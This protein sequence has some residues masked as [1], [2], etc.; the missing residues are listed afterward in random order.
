MNPKP[1]MPEVMCMET[2]IPEFR[3]RHKPCQGGGFMNKVSLI[4]GKDRRR[5]I[6]KSLEQIS[7]DI[8]KNLKPGRIIIKPNF[9]SSSIQ[10]AAS[11]VDQIRG[12]LDYLREFYKEKIIIAEAACDDTTEA[13]KDFGYHNLLKEYN[14]ELIDLNKGPFEKVH[15]LDEKNRTIHVMVSS[16]LLDRNNYLISAAKLKTHDSV[17][18]TLSIKNTAMGCIF[19]KDKIRVHQGVKHLN[20]NIAELSKSVWPDLAI[21]DGFVGMEGNGPVDGSPIHAGV[22]VSGADPL[23]ADRVACELM[24]IDFNKVGYLRYC[25]E[26][27]LG[28]ADL[29]QIEIV[30][31]AF[32]E[33]VMPFRLHS[34]VKEQYKWKD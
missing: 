18:V 3:Q 4:K 24:G 1:F 31:H 23:A 5:N 34:S 27:G 32:R 28:E 26:K 2:P 9:V 12:I 25:S 13:Y 16:L 30:G 19:T 10:L 7:D 22:A 20:L 17:V 29:Q 14:V 21:I 8:R 15:I 33:C 6:R 11:H